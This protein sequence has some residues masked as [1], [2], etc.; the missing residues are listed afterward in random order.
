MNFVIT[1]FRFPMGI[2]ATIFVIV[3]YLIPF[4][5]ELI[6]VILLLPFAAI[7]MRRDELKNSWIGSFPNTIRCMM[8]NIRSIWKWVNDD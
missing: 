7:F 8:S 3:I 4:P 1:F 2:F 6:L 5:V